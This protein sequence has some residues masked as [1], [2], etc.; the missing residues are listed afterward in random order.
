MTAIAPSGKHIAVFFD[1]DGTLLAPPSLERQ[2][3][4]ALRR[5]GAIP[6]RNYYLWLARAARLSA[7][8]LAGMRHANKMYLRGIRASECAGK[9]QQTAQPGF[10]AHKPRDGAAVAVP[11]FFPAAIDQVLWHARRGHAIVLVSGT[12]EPLAMEVGLALTMLLAMRGVAATVAVCATQL[13][14][15]GGRWTGRIVGEAMFGEAKARAAGRMIRENK[16]DA[17]QC[18]AYG[19]SWSD[20]PMLDAVGQAAVVNP[21][22]RL[23][24]VARKKNW[25]VLTWAERKNATQSSLR[26]QRARRRVEEIWEKVG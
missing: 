11:R 14:E 23:A 15:N 25:Q 8:G 26:T 22:W 9:K 2:F 3:V 5:Q 19:N 21:S 20:L 12:L 7:G 17:R 4:A 6:L 18:Y 24:G 16:L 1:I 10:I 13:E